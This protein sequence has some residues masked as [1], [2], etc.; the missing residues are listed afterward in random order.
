MSTLI[1]FKNRLGISKDVTRELNTLP[2]LAGGT[3]AITSRL[4]ARE[5]NPDLCTYVL[6]NRVEVES[7][8]TVQVPIG[9]KRSATEPFEIA[10]SVDKS[11]LK[12]INKV[13]KKPAEIKI[14]DDE[15]NELNMECT[16]EVFK[17]WMR[18]DL[19]FNIVA[20]G[21]E[22]RTTAQISE[23]T[24]IIYETKTTFSNNEDVLVNGLLGYS[25]TACSEQNE[26]LIAVT[27]TPGIPFIVLADGT[28]VDNPVSFD[29]L[30]DGSSSHIINLPCHIIT[31]MIIEPIS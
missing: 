29:A 6:W 8:F 15:D 4:Q 25:C 30:L 17:K 3:S 2:Q 16:I 20:K 22:P 24:N 10:I 5:S 9:F 1:R 18:G 26:E 21:F 19:L 7:L 28:K 27:V 13:T 11:Y 31:E 12:L 23:T 14:L